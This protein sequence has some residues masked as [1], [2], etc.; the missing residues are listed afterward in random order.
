MTEKV[1]LDIT[2]KK[3]LSGAASTYEF[4]LLI[5]TDGMSYLSAD[6][7]G[8]VHLLKSWRFINPENKFREVEAPIRSIFAQ[9]VNLNLQYGNSRVAVFNN[10]VTL[11]PN[12]LFSADELPTYFNLLIQ[13][14]S[15]LSYRYDDV[16]NLD[17]KVVFAVDK[18]IIG[19][20][21]QNYPKTKLTHS[22]S[23]LLL[24]WHRLARR[25]EYDVFV[26]LRNQIA[27]I[28]VFDRQNLQFYNSFPFSKAS[29][30][31]YFCLLAFDQLKLNPLDVTLT[32]TGELME[33]SEIYRLLYRYFRDIRFAETPAGL[34]QFSGPVDSLP[35][36]MN[37]D[38]Y[39][40]KYGS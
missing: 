26:N 20:I 13:P 29:D 11:V 8:E 9:D 35:G 22:A 34:Y 30:F 25:S 40:M 38:L 24:A 39:A 16:K 21:E 2:D 28:A 37:F 23:S 19:F 17:V 14:E 27:Q 10:L 1:T 5:G 12:R 3:F 32:I 6:P 31:L 7:K 33:D 15:P 4:S 18:N 36:H